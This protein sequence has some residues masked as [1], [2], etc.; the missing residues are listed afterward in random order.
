MP[1]DM[2]AQILMKYIMTSCLF[3]LQFLFFQTHT[4]CFGNDCIVLDWMESWQPLSS[5]G[6]RQHSMER[7][8]LSGIERCSATTASWCEFGIQCLYRYGTYWWCILHLP[9]YVIISNTITRNWYVLLS[10]LA[11]NY[12]YGIRLCI[13]RLRSNSTLWCPNSELLS[14]SE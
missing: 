13:N 2:F 14:S 10:Y 11:T 1:A 4:L 12:F 3:T 6:D 5:T 7:W 8:C 9:Y